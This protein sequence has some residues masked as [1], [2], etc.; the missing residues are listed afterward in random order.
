MMMDDPFG[1]DV[2]FDFDESVLL[3]CETEEAE[4]GSLTVKE[5]SEAP[6]NAHLK[7]LSSSFGYSAFRPVQ[8][9]IISRVLCDAGDSLVVM[10]TGYGKSLC[11][12]FPAV[13]S[14]KVTLVISPLISLMEDQVAKLRVSNI[15]STFLGS[16]QTMMPDTMSNIKENKYRV[17]YVTPEYVD[18][19]L[20]TLSKLLKDRLVLV[21]VD[22]AHCVSQWG[23]DFRSSYRKLGILKQTFP[24]VPIMGLTA[25]ATPEV[26]K[27]ISKSLSLINPSYFV[28][29]FDRP[30]LFIEVKSKVAIWRDLSLLMTK[31]N[32]EDWV[33]PHGSTIIYCPTR[34]E[35]EKVGDVLTSNSVNH[36]L[37]HAGLSPK[38]LEWVLTKIGRAGRDGM[39][40]R[41]RVYYSTTDFSVHRFF[42][43]DMENGKWKEY[44]RKMMHEMEI[45]LSL[46]K[47]C[48]RF[49]LLSHFDS[50]LVAS[51]FIARKD[52]C[53]NCDR[54]LENSDGKDSS[55]DEVID[56][57]E[58]AKLFLKTFSLTSGKFG[59]GLS[60]SIIRGAKDKYI[61]DYHMRSPIFGMGKLKPKQYWMALG[62]SLIERG[63][64]LENRVGGFGPTKFSY[65]IYDI[66][67]K[68][69]IFLRNDNSRLKM[70]PTTDLKPIQTKTII[71][72]PSSLPP[73]SSEEQKFRN[74]LTVVLIKLRSSL[75]ERDGAAPY[76]ILSEQTIRTLSVVRPSKLE[77][78]SKIEGFTDAKKSVNTAKVLS[79]KSG[80][81]VIRLTYTFFQEKLSIDEVAVTRGLKEG[82][83][84]SHLSEAIKIGLPITDIHSLCPYNKMKQI[85][86]VI[87]ASLDSNCLKED[88]EAFTLSLEGIKK[89]NFEEMEVESVKD[90]EREPTQEMEDP[91]SSTQS[92]DSNNSSSQDVSLKRSSSDQSKRS[93]IKKLKSNSLFK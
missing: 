32:G 61:Q 73:L 48:R 19:S 34:K 10:A 58:D 17:V 6:S 1:D 74:S 2:D 16:G 53:D 3:E 22:E 56:F 5:D 54:S 79:K 68:G 77:Y 42:L 7:I 43:S 91:Q 25:T 92:S 31:E 18:T 57:T 8:W 89:P 93:L 29:S 51:D 38:H 65:N 27:D 72:T 52:C 71:V 12:Q 37:Y 24:N 75:A 84:Y 67:D 46:Q 36:L 47:K 60:C 39:S 50:N 70:L 14:G 88:V 85:T 11:Y 82:T 64:I 76:M 40:S 78:L 13:Y 63:Y 15:P 26:Q 28:T 69:R 9:N 62:R 4:N 35:V 21:A 87:Y 33:F 44:R 45:Y 41:V 20:D 83:I 81:G 66:S 80:N 49:L 86:E 90:I 55:S 59:L 23:H 30:N